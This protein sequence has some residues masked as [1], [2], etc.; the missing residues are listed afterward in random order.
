MASP[1]DRK[2]HGDVQGHPVLGASNVRSFQQDDPLGPP[3]IPP[4]LIDHKEDSP[5]VT[6][7][8]T[9]NTADLS[10]LNNDQNTQ[11]ETVATVTNQPSKSEDD[12]DD[13][14]IE[15]SPEKNPVESSNPNLPRPMIMI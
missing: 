12:H 8:D 15:D 7:D 11:S 4:D 14:L 6:T 5:V 10:Y 1:E 13:N 3:G 2:C 9:I